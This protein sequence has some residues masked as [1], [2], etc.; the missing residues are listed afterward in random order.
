MYSEKIKCKT[1]KNINVQ[2][3]GREKEV[4]RGNK[5]KDSE[6]EWDY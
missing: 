5:K 3:M 4:N 6:S 2:R 1:L